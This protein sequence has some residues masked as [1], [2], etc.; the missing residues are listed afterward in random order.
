MTFL[1]HVFEYLVEG[2]DDGGIGEVFDWDCVDAVC[3]VIIRHIVI[4]VAVNGS[5]RKD[6]CSI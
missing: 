4:L 2:L 6:A 1:L 5:D 3:V